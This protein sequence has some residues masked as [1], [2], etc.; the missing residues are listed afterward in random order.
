MSCLSRRS[1]IACPSSPFS[2]CISTSY[3]LRA[4]PPHPRS[5]T[6]AL[7][8]ALLPLKH[9][10]QASSPLL[11][12]SHPHPHTI[13]QIALLHSL[14]LETSLTRDHVDKQPTSLPVL[15]GNHLMTSSDLANHFISYLNTAADSNLYIT[16]QPLR[17]GNTIATIYPSHGYLRSIPFTIC[18]SRTQVGWWS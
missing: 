11:L 7:A 14:S 2:L 9:E 8:L 17:R 12:S 5:I 15:T 18:Q 4:T 13:P 1:I 16:P 6:V 10:P 3:A